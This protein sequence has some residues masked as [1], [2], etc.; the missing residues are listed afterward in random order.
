MPLSE[1]T[2][3]T[4]PALFDTLS[5]HL[6]ILVTKYNDILDDQGKRSE[7]NHFHQ[8][9]TIINCNFRLIAR[10]MLC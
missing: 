3:I 1:L 5:Q 4:R 6:N 2:H 8:L 10:L 7:A 9:N